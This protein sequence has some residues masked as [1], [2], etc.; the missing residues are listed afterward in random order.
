MSDPVV[1]WTDKQAEALALAF[2]GNRCILAGAGSGKTMTLVELILRLLERGLGGEGTMDLS[3]VL[4]LTYTEKAA[5]EMRDRVRLGLNKRI[6]N[7]TSEN[8]AFWVKQRR[9]LDRA[10]ISTIHSFCLQVLRQHGLEA[11]LDPDFGMLEEDRTFLADAQRQVLLDWL[12]QK[13][14]DLIDLLDY[15]NWLSLGRGRGLDYMLSAITG[16]ERTFGRPVIP[17]GM[18]QPAVLDGNISALKAAVDLVDQLVDEGKLSPDKSYFKTVR[19]FANTARPFLDGS[20][21]DILDALDDISL[22]IQGNW[23]AA[24]PAREMANDALDALKAERDRRLAQ[25]LQEKLLT[26]ARR[27]GESM[28]LAKERRGLLDFDD[29]LLLTRDA[30]ARHPEIRR[31]LKARFRMVLVDE[32]QD[33]NRLQADIMAF[34][35]EPEGQEIVLPPG[36]SPLDALERASDRLV[37]FGDPKQSI[38]RFRGA[39]VSVFNRLK[40]SIVQD[41]RSGAG[42]VISL[43]KN[44]RSR[45]QLIDFYNLFFP[46]IMPE[47]ARD[48]ESEYGRHDRQLWERP[49]LNKRPAAAIL[50]PP[51]GRNMAEDRQMEAEYLAAF[52]TEVFSGER[53]ILVSDPGRLPEP[54]DVAVLLRRFTHLKAYE[55]AFRRWKLPTYTVRG[56]GF[57]QCAEVWDLINLMFYLTDL[58]SG[59]PLLGLLRSPLFGLDDATL[60]RLVWP[61]EAAS[62][63]ELVSYFGPKPPFWPEGVDHERLERVRNL[64]FSLAVEAGRA[65][66]AEVVERVVEETDY[67]AVLLAQPQGEQKVAN[68][69]RFIEITRRWP[70]DALYAPGEAARFLDARLQDHQDDP[71]A[72]PQA[73]ATQAIQIMTIHQAK[74]LQFPVVLIPDAGAEMIK[75]TNPVLFGSEDR[76]TIRFKDPETRE[77]RTP[78]EY[79]QFRDENEARER[80]EHVR[81]LYVAATRAQDY[82]LFSGLPKKKKDT[83]SWLAWL[84]EFADQKPELLGRVVVE[85]NDPNSAA[86]VDATEEAADQVV[87]ITDNLPSPPQPG[88]SGHEI[89]TRV[90]DKPPAIPSFLTLNVTGLAQYLTCPRRFYLENILGLPEYSQPIEM[91]NTES[92]RMS[93]RIKGIL[94]H[95]L[96]ETYDLETQPDHETLAQRVIARASE[97]GWPCPNDVADELAGLAVEFLDNPWGHDLIQARDGLVQRESPIWLRIDPDDRM[98][99]AMI[100]T[101]EIDLFYITPTGL[102]RVVD[103]KYALPKDTG[104]YEPQVKAY[105][106]ALIRAGLS[107]KLEAGLYFTG[108]QAGQLVEFDLS[109]GWTDEFEDR[110]RTAALGLGRIMGPTAEEP[111][112]MEPCPDHTCGFEYACR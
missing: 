77:T 80:A 89:L 5:R 69:Q 53:E 11:G 35:T 14:P 74:G 65:F 46:R 19:N 1:K 68:V 17:A 3:Q 37:V 62:P 25:P 44:F 73:E 91:E 54:K 58:S 93:P 34:L 101:G 13:D 67:L 42:R 88:D 78:T 64:I 72:Q 84:N 18:D 56:K 83:E 106:L 43:N 57:Y 100:L 49:S 31:K 47:K 9:L 2:T 38:Y 36:I 60:T 45:K 63:R 29:L 107:R 7:A 112:P 61:A 50:T 33:T 98:G 102:A 94:F 87:D 28:V 15:F 26:L 105:A 59:P 109:G 10:Q 8:R 81:L 110:L 41:D 85:I 111:A 70:R 79:R 71:E 103:Y 6:K 52:L 86:D 39:E 21:A 22:T 96:L 51:K 99:P 32:F 76:F 24:K 108:H 66:P 23:Y 55:Q 40:D 95:Y 92:S 104:R 48:Y 90:L 12:H 82:L 20:E 4:A 97:D 27:M 16:Y 30:L 75:S